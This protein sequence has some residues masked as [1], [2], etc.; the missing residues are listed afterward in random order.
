MVARGD[1]VGGRKE[2]GDGDEEVQ[3][4]SCQINE[5]WDERHSVG[6]IVNN[7]VLSF[8]MVIILKCI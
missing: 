8:I 5:S 7:N 1:R 3:I 6:N 2:I 4:L